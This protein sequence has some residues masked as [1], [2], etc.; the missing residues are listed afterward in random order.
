MILD[1]QCVWQDA[2]YAEKEEEE[3]TEIETKKKG[4]KKKRKGKKARKTNMAVKN[5]NQGSSSSVL[6]VP[7]T[8]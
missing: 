5:I 3:R 7:F 6:D 4:K 8:K 1:V 2:M